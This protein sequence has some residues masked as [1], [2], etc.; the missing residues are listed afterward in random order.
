MTR[1][2]PPLNGWRKSSYSGGEGGNCV[3]AASMPSIVLVR[4][5]RAAEGSVLT[6]P[7]QSWKRFVRQLKT[8]Y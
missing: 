2:S 7:A 1:S 4:D 5:S 8:H 6:C 3:E